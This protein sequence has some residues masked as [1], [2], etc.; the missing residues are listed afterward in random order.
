MVLGIC[1][2]LRNGGM[3]CR[4]SSRGLHGP[5]AK[6]SL[7]SLIT[8]MN[9]D[10][11]LADLTW[12]SSPSL[13]SSQWQWRVCSRSSPGE[14]TTSKKQFLCSPGGSPSMHKLKA[15]PCFRQTK[16]AG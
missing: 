3:E 5:E 1:M 2:S 13:C 4:L 10:R 16:G 14:W 12:A 8:E 15:M 7:D 9:T 11:E 6:T